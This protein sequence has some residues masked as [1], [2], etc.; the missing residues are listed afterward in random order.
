MVQVAPQAPLQSP[1]GASHSWERHEREA[2]G[3]GKQCLAFARQPPAA[4]H[5]PLPSP[6][7]HPAAS[8]AMSRCLPCRLHNKHAHTNLTPAH[9]L[10]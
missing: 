10:V 4:T 2:G 8:P 6:H 9:S 7:T 1:P 3:S 5:H